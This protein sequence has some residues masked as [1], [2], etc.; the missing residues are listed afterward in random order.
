MTRNA[1]ATKLRD[2]VALTQFNWQKANAIFE[3]IR[4]RT[5]GNSR[6]GHFGLQN[7]GH[8]ELVLIMWTSAAKKIS[9]AIGKIDSDLILLRF[10]AQPVKGP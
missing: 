6:I 1:H 10:K 8:L 3:P 7:Y 9:N 4:H 5:M 2:V